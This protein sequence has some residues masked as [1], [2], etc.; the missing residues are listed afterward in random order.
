MDKIGHAHT[1]I[2]QLKKKSKILMH[3]KLE[4]PQ[5]VL[6][7]KPETKEHIVYY[8]PEMFRESKP[9]GTEKEMQNLLEF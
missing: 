8:L 9:I 5:I 1:I 3:T 4:V 6:Q 2:Q 7:M